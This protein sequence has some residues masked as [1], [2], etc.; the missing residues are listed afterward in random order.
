MPASI[1]RPSSLCTAVHVFAPLVVFLGSSRCR[2]LAPSPPLPIYCQVLP[3]VQLR[4]YVGLPPPLPSALLLNTKRFGWLW[5]L[6]TL[7]RPQLGGLRNLAGFALS[8]CRPV[9]GG[10]WGGWGWPITLPT[11]HSPLFR[12]R[13][14]GLP[15]SSVPYLD[16]FRGLRLSFPVPMWV[17]VRYLGSPGEVRLLMGPCVQGC[18]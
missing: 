18:V 14:G 10:L 16:R 2:P 1:P 13:L 17:V 3:T 11:H 12:L 4:S 6:S 9:P 8:R 5:N 15:A 7:R